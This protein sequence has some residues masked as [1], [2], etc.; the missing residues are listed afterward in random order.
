MIKPL[1]EREPLELADDVGTISLDDEI[2]EIK[3]ERDENE[4]ER[5]AARKA[6]KANRTVR[7][8]ESA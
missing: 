3:A 2:A 8:P 4:E 5:R 1:I 6:R 7:K